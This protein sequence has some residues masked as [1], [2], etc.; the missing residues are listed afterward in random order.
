MMGIEGKV[1]VQFTIDEVGNIK[2]IK[3]LQ[4][5]LKELDNEAIRVIKLMSGKWNPGK[6]GGKAVKTTMVLPITFKL[7]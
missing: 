3:V 1:L 2:D 5:L 6:Q 7:Q 4:G